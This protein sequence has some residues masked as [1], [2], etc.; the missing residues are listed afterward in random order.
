MID[1][2]RRRGRHVKRA[3]ALC[4]L[5]GLLSTNAARAD[6]AGYDRAVAELSGWFIS[7]PEVVGYFTAYGAALALKGYGAERIKAAAEQEAEGLITRGMLRLTFSDVYRRVKLLSSL[8]ENAPLATCAGAAK[9]KSGLAALLK[10]GSYVKITQLFDIG[11]KAVLLEIRRANDLGDD[12]GQ[13]ELNTRLANLSDL[14][15]VALGVGILADSPAVQCATGRWALSSALT[16][17]S[18]D[19]EAFVRYMSSQF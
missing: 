18:G 2:D 13:E 14:D 9:G 12:D 7:N 1:I 16:D 4:S 5:I 3:A 15:K 17:R 10:T 6:E 8:M 19:Y 11:K